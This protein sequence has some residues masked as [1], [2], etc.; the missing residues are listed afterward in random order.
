MSRQGETLEFQGFLGAQFCLP[1]RLVERPELLTEIVDALRA[2]YG[3]VAVTGTGGAGKSTLAALACLDRRV[4]RHYR[5][6]I[7]WLEASPG[8]DPVELLATLAHRLGMSRTA[9]SFATVEQGRKLL[10]PMLLGKRLLVA[11]DNVSER[12]LLDAV[13][14][15]TPACT[16][17]FSTRLPELAGMVKASQIVVDRLSHDQSLELLG[18][19]TGQA[20]ATFPPEAQQLCTESGEMPLSVALAGGMVASGS[21]FMAAL[22][23]VKPFPG[24]PDAGSDPSYQVRTVFHAIEAGIA[25]LPK[26]AQTRYEE[27]AVFAG[28]GPF[29][30]DAAQAL[31][32]RDLPDAAAHRLLAEL[33][34]RALLTARGEGRRQP[35]SRR[36]V[37][38]TGKASGPGCDAGIWMTQQAVG[39]MRPD[40]RRVGGQRRGRYPQGP[41]DLASE[42]IARIPVVTNK[43]MCTPVGEAGLD[44]LG[45]GKNSAQFAAEMC[46]VQVTG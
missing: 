37:S 2:R 21:S 20:P 15:L 36:A 31:W 6:G 24:W 28:R 16:V 30:A 27:L 41:H 17:L 39:E 34:G 19:W 10:Q 23:S 1:D 35:V 18:S 44:P 45:V 46:V 42:R 33:T 9:M 5:D 32:Y 8:Q 25:A 3:L 29:P 13:R 12:P 4:R 38:A 11:V 40:E 26:T 22:D 43:L 7:A 14:D